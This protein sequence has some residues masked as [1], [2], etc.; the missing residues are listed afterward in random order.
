MMNIIRK[1]K[2]GL[3]EVTVKQMVP[4]GPHY[5]RIRSDKRRNGILS[6]LIGL[7]RSFTTD[8][9]LEYD[10][11]FKLK[12]DGDVQFTYK[13]ETVDLT[14]IPYYRKPFRFYKY[15]V[16][17]AGIKRVGK[18]VKDYFRNKHT[19]NSYS[20]TKL[21]ELVGKGDNPFPWK[22]NIQTEPTANV[23][24]CSDKI[25]YRTEYRDHF[26]TVE[27]RFSDKVKR[28]ANIL[29]EIPG[30]GNV[31]N[32]D[33][34]GVKLVRRQMQTADFR[35]VLNICLVGVSHDD[36]FRIESHSSG[37][38]GNN[39]RAKWGYNGKTTTLKPH[40][41]R[42]VE[43]IEGTI[44][45]AEDNKKWTD[46]NKAELNKNEAIFG[47]IYSETGLKAEEET[48]RDL[49]A[50]PLANG[51]YGNYGYVATKDGAKFCIVNGGR[52]KVGEFAYTCKASFVSFHVSFSSATGFYTMDEM[53]NTMA[54][55]ST[56]TREDLVEVIK[57]M[58]KGVDRNFTKRISVF[59]KCVKDGF[60]MDEN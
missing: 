16:S 7:M 44:D 1:I 52:G 49:V 9:I 10:D 23:V 41:K 4:A 8:S 55:F 45:R 15:V 42:L 54:G 48:V 53:D 32:D 58:V 47:G 37:L 57:I 59:V 26:P 5:K 28:S 39:H 17:V 46:R 43:K 30:R 12:K 34:Y 14:L 40:L 36:K 2:D 24:G 60:C 6:K 50:L 22:P 18:E 29:A 35:M 51:E 25:P 20:Y 19:F 56:M 3:F 11:R 38:D 21:D 13:G 33:T 31:F 27:V